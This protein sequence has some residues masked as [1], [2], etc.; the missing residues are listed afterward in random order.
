MQDVSHAK[1]TRAAYAYCRKVNKAHYEN[2]PVASVLL[3]K[4][5]RPAVDAIYAFSRMAD[6][7]ADEKL[8]EGQRMERLTEWGSYLNQDE[9]T[10]P[11]F[12]AL[13]DAIRVHNIPK[14]LLL[15]LLTA[16]KQDVVKSRYQT[17]REVLEYCRYSAN[18][19]GRLVLVVN[20]QASETTNGLSDAVCTAL[21]LANF[22]QDVAVDFAKDRIY[23]PQDECDFLKAMLS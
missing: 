8:Y 9:P 6:D 10:H 20:G 14:V 5:L 22:W 18:P 3:P 23:L 12:V 17:F 11:V 2:F 7:F 16:F 4:H 15:D 1:L 19:V 21:Q 13:K